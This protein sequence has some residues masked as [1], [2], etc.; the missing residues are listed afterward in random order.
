MKQLSLAQGGF[1]KY[2]KPNRRAE[3]LAQ[4]DRVVP[5]QELCALIEPH[6]PKAG[7]GRPPVGLERMLRLHFL[8]HWYN[9]SDPGLEEELLGSESMRRFVGIDLGV[10]RV[11][12]ETAVCKFRHP[13]ERRC[14][15]TRGA[16]TRLTRR[17]P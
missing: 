4:M 6:Y 15:S 11:P 12:D 9:L 10:E 7:R 5:W 3:F 16:S 2:A 1:E 14:I 8:Q 13:K 17:V